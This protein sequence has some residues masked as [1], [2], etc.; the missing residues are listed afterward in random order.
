MTFLAVVIAIILVCIFWRIFLSLAG[1]AVVAFIV[2][3]VI[4]TATGQPL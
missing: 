3:A 2:L 4:V 1:I